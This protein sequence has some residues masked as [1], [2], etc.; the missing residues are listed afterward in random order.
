MRLID[1]NNQGSDPF[2]PLRSL[3]SPLGV[4]R[5]KAAVLGASHPASFWRMFRGFITEFVAL[6]AMT[7]V[8]YNFSFPSSEHIASATS[9]PRM[10]SIAAI[11]NPLPAN[12]GSYAALYS[13]SSKTVAHR[14]VNSIT[15]SETNWASE[16]PKAITP[17]APQEE[18]IQ[19]VAERD[20]QSNIDIELPKASVVREESPLNSDAASDHMFSASVA[21]GAAFGHI[22]MMTEGLNLNATSGWQFVSLEYMRASGQHD[23]VDELKHHPN[24]AKLQLGEDRQQF[25]I[26]GGVTLPIGP[27]EARASIGPSYLILKTTSASSAT[28]IADDPTTLYHMGAQCELEFDH[29]FNSILQAGIRGTAGYYGVPTGAVLLTISLTP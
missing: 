8:V 20:V 1:I 25:S 13:T 26:M 9:A 7:A 29:H 18:S 17:E 28:K 2:G 19:P 21:S 10:S 14:R 11:S 4:E 23:L 16:L 12:S 5:I 6:G 3:S 15:P 27:I 24:D 22:R